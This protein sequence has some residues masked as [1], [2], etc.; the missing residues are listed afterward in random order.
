MLFENKFTN[1]LKMLSY[2]EVVENIKQTYTT[3]IL[4]VKN[5]I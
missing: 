4:K 2:M 5:S 3:Y 1:K